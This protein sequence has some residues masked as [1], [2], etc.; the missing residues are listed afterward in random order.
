MARLPRHCIDC[1]VTDPPWGVAVLFEGADP[2]KLG[3]RDS[4]Q[5][6]IMQ[7]DWDM[8][9]PEILVTAFLKV[10]RLV[11]KNKAHVFMFGPWCWMLWLP[12]AT[13]RWTF[14]RP[15]FWYKSNMVAPFPNQ[16][17]PCYEVIYHLQ[18]ELPS[19]APGEDKWHIDHYIRDVFDY[20]MTNSEHSDGDHHPSMKPVA[21]LKEL[22]NI[23]S[24]PGDIIMDPFAGSGS[25]GVAAKA[26]GRWPLLVEKED[27]YCRTIEKRLRSTRAEMQ[28]TLKG[29]EDV[30]S[31]FKEVG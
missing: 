3:M 21:V 12:K 8:I 18:A 26:T 20:C 10:L 7:S 6:R 14:H 15:L 23:S 17:S 4:G 2:E 13:Q 19:I 16:L 22:I 11:V 25:T 5:N 28:A 29:D 27:K 30:V 1:V 9:D 24:R 31:D